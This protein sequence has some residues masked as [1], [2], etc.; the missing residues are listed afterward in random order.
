MVG[1]LGTT[2]QPPSSWVYPLWLVQRRNSCYWKFGVC[3]PIP[4]AFKAVRSPGRGAGAQGRW[5]RRGHQEIKAFCGKVVRLG[6]D[7]CP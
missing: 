7:R 3:R 2:G 4:E 5:D 1:V 6:E